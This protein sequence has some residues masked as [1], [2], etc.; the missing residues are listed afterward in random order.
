MSTDNVIPFPDL[1]PAPELMS[2]TGIHAL[3]GDRLPKLNAETVLSGL[4]NEITPAQ[5]VENFLDCKARQRV[6]KVGDEVIWRSGWG[7]GAPRP[8]RVKRIEVDCN[9]LAED[10][11]LVDELPWGQVH[12]R[13]TVVDLENGSWA[14]GTQLWP[15]MES[16][17]LRAKP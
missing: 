9:Q 16:A 17:L 1:R 3:Y 5:V 11:V 13:S 2:D 8:A 4:P 7:E 14:Y 10:G 15:D 6:L 12:T